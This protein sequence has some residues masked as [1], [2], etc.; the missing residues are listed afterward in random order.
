KVRWHQ[1]RLVAQTKVV[2]ALPVLIHRNESEGPGH[3]NNKD[4][5]VWMLHE[6][7]LRLPGDVAVEGSQRVGCPFVPS[8]CCSS[9]TPVNCPLRCRRLFLTTNGADH[10]DATL[11]VGKARDV[12]P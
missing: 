3:G 11:G 12:A 9:W 2:D 1:Q 5:S 8:L 6:V 4:L 10:Q 7:D